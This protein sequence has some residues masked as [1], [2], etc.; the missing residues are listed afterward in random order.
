MRISPTNTTTNQTNIGSRSNTAKRN[1]SSP[2]VREQKVSKY[3]PKAITKASDRYL[4][5]ASNIADLY[6][7]SLIP[8]EY[9]VA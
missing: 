1:T 3:Q 7:L 2:D 8:I 6:Y 9:H 4:S 5:P